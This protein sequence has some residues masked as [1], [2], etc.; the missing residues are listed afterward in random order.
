MTGASPV[1]GSNTNATGVA[2]AVAE[3]APA[4]AVFDRGVKV[5]G[6]VQNHVHRFTHVYGRPSSLLPASGDRSIV[7]FGSRSNA[8]A[9]WASIAGVNAAGTGR[10]G[11]QPTP[12]INGPRP[13][14]GQ[15]RLDEPRP[16]RV[17][18]HAEIGR[19][20]GTPER[21]RGTR[22][23]RRDI[24]HRHDLDPVPRR[25]P[26]PPARHGPGAPA[27]GPRSRPSHRTRQ[28]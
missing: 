18:V 7:G 28:V 8:Y 3:I 23:R 2:V 19:R 10:S 16:P 20:A 15:A 14:G 9:R 17:A 26:E 13:V 27:S 1:P 25:P 12:C 4:A 22:I 21:V 6:S 11:G 24:R 5:A